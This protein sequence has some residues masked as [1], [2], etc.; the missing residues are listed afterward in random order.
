[1]LN[2]FSD[3]FPIKFF[4]LIRALVFFFLLTKTFSITIFAAEP[5]ILKYADEFIG[6][7]DEI[8]NTRT[9]LGNVQLQQKNVFIKCN[10]AI[11]FLNSNKFLLKGNVI[12]TQESLTLKSE[13][14]L[15][16]GNAYLATSDSSVRITDQKIQLLG[17]R[18]TYS[19]DKMIADFYD[20]V[21]LEDDSVKIYADYVS[22]NRKSKNSKA[23]GDILLRGKTENI[24]LQSDTIYNF[25]EENKTTAVGNPV[26]FQI[27]TIK[28]N[29]SSEE[30][31]A[32]EFDTLSIKSDSIIAFR[33]NENEKNNEKY[34]FINNVE[35]IRNSL[36]ALACK[37]YYLPQNEQVKLF[38]KDLIEEDNSEKDLDKNNSRVVI[39][40]DS[41]QLISDSVIVKIQNNK[42]QNI[43]SYNNSIIVIKDDTTNFARINQLFGNEIELF[44]NNDSLKKIESLGNAKSVFFTQ[45]AGNADGVIVNSAEKIIIEIENGEAENFILIKE[46]LGKYHPEPLVFGVETNFYLNEFPAEIIKSTN[47]PIQPKIREKIKKYLEN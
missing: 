14:I 33:G 29:N 27:D 47:I 39:W 31:S 13:H 17:K 23:I 30:N 10:T 1:M 9:L 16:D 3:N 5:V 44:I 20:E 37:V 18:G 26:L 32:L 28:N 40:L 8:Q 24:F 42:L 34:D 11:Q 6:E 19:T 15:Y 38:S 35:I 22:Y 21:E 4:H 36:K 46:I 43:H 45:K 41:T 12:I 7:S 2:N 25:F